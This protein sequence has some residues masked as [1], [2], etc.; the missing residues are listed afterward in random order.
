MVSISSLVI[1]VS[2]SSL[3]SSLFILMA[4]IMVSNYPNYIFNKEVSSTAL[5]T[6]SLYI[7]LIVVGNHLSMVI[8]HCLLN[9]YLKPVSLDHDKIYTCRLDHTYLIG[10]ICKEFCSL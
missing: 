3:I 5:I 6:T 7:I 2:I 4:L 10:N 1:K 9:L 8:K